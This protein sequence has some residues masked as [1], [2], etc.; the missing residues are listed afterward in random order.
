[1]QRAFETAQIDPADVALIELDGTGLPETDQEQLRAVV[2]GYGRSQRSEPLLISSGHRPDRSHDWRFGH[3]LVD[4]SQL[5]G[6][7]R[8]HA[9]HVRT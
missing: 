4:Q 8:R 3:G 5:R 1:M 7:K 9:G 2:A 6:R